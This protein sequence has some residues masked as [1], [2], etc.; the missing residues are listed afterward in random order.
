MLK[1]L[2][3]NLIWLAVPLGLAVGCASNEASYAPETTVGLALPGHDMTLAPTSSHTTRSR[4]YAEGGTH[5]EDTSSTFSTDVNIPPA[6]ANPQ[7]WDLAQEI[8]WKLISDQSL[9]PMG[10]SLTAQVSNDG[11]VTLQGA[12]ASTDEQQR[13]GDTIS[14]LPGVKSVDNQLKIGMASSSGSLDTQQPQ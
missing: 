5:Y 1:A 13:V 4:V 14:S 10:S 11:V 6:G 2:C 3:K 12:V 7:T 8:Q 9:A